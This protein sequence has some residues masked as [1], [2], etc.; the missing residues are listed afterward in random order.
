[1][2]LLIAVGVTGF[3][4]HVQADYNM[5]LRQF[6]F[7]RFVRGAPFMAPLLFADMGTLGLV[8]LLD[9]RGRKPASI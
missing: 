6:V 2:L 7:E 4:L 1:M 9:P 3:I 5:G 8:V